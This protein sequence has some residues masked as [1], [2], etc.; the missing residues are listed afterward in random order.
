MIFNI[1]SCFTYHTYHHLLSLAC[2]F[3]QNITFFQTKLILKMYCIVTIHL[4]NTELSHSDR[5]THPT[6]HGD[7]E[8]KTGNTS[9]REGHSNRAGN[10]CTLLFMVSFS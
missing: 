1:I 4:N 3:P 10:S 9:L 8:K 6:V 7:A 5:H 2:P